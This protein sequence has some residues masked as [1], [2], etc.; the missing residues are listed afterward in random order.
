MEE[1][2]LNYFDDIELNEDYLEDSANENQK[3]LEIAKEGREPSLEEIDQILKE[4]EEEEKYYKNYREELKNISSELEK[5]NT[6]LDK[7]YEK[8]GLNTTFE[9]VKEARY[10]KIV[11]DEKFNKEDDEKFIKEYRDMNES[12]K[13]YL[14]ENDIPYIEISGEND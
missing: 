9:A 7:V 13:K 1:N 14:E 11:K 12:N 3:I 5:L 2:N 8:Y 4:A 6:D 10:R